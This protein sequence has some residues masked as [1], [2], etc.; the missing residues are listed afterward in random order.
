MARSRASLHADIWRNPDWV[1]RS[2][3][4]QRLFMLILS[5][6]KLTLAG[7]VD[8]KVDRW[9]VLCAD[10]DGD[11][12][13]AALAELEASRFVIVDRHTGEV[14]VRTFA[15]HDIDGSRFNRNLAKGFWSAWEAVE[16]D[17]LRSEIVHEMPKDTWGK[18]EEFAPE[19]GKQ[20]RRSERLERP[21]G[22]DRS[23]G[24]SEPT[25]RTMSCVLSPES[26]EPLLPPNRSDGPST[27]APDPDP[28]EAAAALTD[29]ERR[30]RF[31]AAVDVLVDRHLNRNPSIAPGPHRRS[32]TAGK[33]TDHSE[34]AMAHLL[35]RPDLTAEQLADLLEPTGRP[36]ATTRHLRA[37]EGELERNAARLR[38]EACAKCDGSGW[39]DVE[40]DHGSSVA[41][42]NDCDTTSDRVRQAMNGDA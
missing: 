7:S 36:D 1:D 39:I 21:V 22:T 19:R 34:A 24:P 11:D 2:G 9:A 16:S 10:W 13:E 33:R 4:A 31:H 15:R 5:Q 12:V 20:T 32:V 41:R 35:Q 25:D 8:L 30:D 23:N 26:C 27:E 17:Y 18:L 3:N 40:T 37:I 29:K 14:A 6:P 42:C 38:G 28:D